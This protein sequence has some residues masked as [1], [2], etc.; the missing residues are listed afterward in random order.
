[1]QPNLRDSRAPPHK[2][3][4]PRR[5][6]PPTQQ[7]QRPPSSLDVANAPDATTPTAVPRRRDPT[8]DHL[9][10]TPSGIDPASPP[11]SPR[12]TIKYGSQDA[13]CRSC[14]ACTFWR[15]L[16]RTAWS[17]DAAAAFSASPCRCL[18]SRSL[19]P[20]APPPRPS[21]LASRSHDVRPSSCCCRR[22]G[23]SSR[24]PGVLRC[25]VGGF[26][27]AAAAARGRLLPFGPGSAK[28]YPRLPPDGVW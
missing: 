22:G 25:S 10:S 5:T 15:L 24:D 2:Q 27:L 14:S 7:Q 17:C 13:R 11:L 12:E 23:S 21:I 16:H 4:M 18:D 28:P 26:L 1:M 3:Y 8:P 20:F 19:P 9:R 6:T